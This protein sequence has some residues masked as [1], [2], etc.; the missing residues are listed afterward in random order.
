MASSPAAIHRLRFSVRFMRFSAYLLASIASVAEPA[1]VPAGL[2]SP[3]R[4]A[5]RA[6]VTTERGQGDR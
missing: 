2:A 1:A 4:R 5:G 3:E 6:A